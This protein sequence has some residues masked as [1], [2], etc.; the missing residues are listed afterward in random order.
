M[1]VKSLYSRLAVLWFWLYPVWPALLEKMYLTYCPCSF[2]RSK[3][4]YVCHKLII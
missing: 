3:W 4:C 2:L 1:E